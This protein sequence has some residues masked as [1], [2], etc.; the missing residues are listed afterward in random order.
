MFVTFEGID[1]SGKTSLMQALGQNL[2]ARGLKCLQTREPGGSSLGV[3]L[4][5]L[6][7]GHFEALSPRAELFLFLADRA[8]HVE[9]VILPALKQGL[10]VLCDRFI[11][12]TICY[13][14]YGRGLDLA[15][16]KS[17]NLMACGGLLPE[18]TFWLDLPVKLALARVAS[19]KREQ[20]QIRDES[21]FD[22]EALSFHQRVSQGYALEAQNSARFIRI[23]ASQ[24]FPKVLAACEQY[25]LGR[26]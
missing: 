20:A 6:V 10:I 25:L 9:E 21:R 1:G 7:L 19:R 3:T 5:K 18:V 17:L 12:S 24:A 14:G 4:R 16:L 8:Q 2:T 13:Q 11:D 26:C 15:E 23:D 22:E